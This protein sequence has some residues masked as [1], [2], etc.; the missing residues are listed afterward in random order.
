VLAE[1][2]PETGRAL[3][4]ERIEVAG[5]NAEQAYDADDKPPAANI[6]PATD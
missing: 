3:S 1:I 5:G 4:I 2:D 6:V